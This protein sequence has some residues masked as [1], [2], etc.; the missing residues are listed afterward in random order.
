MSGKGENVDPCCS[1]ARVGIRRFPGCQLPRHR[2]T[3]GSLA[4]RK[5]PRSAFGGGRGRMGKDKS[6]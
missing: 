2:G 4:P 6:A 5:A 3:M 1:K